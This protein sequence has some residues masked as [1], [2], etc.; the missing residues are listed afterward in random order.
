M[1]IA[2]PEDALAVGRRLVAD[3]RHGSGAR[4][5]RPRR[6]GAGPR[7]RP[8]GAGPDP[9]AAGLRH[10]RRGRHGPLGRRALPGR[11]G[12]LRRGRR[13]GERRG[14]AG[15]REDRR[16]AAVAAGDPPRPGRPPPARGRQAARPRSAG[17]R[18]PTPARGGAVDRLHQRLLRPPAPRPRPAAPPGRGPGRLPDRRAQLRRERAAGSRARAGR[19]TRK[20]PAPSCW[21]PWSAWTP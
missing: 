9:A 4:H 21:R 20:T 17:G 1:T 13:A 15:G 10:H 11:R 14:R 19:S 7:R 16:R 3:A 12:R 18:G 6:H 5:A 2:T 8:R